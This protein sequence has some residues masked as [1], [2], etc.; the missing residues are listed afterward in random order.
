MTKVKFC[1]LR[2]PEDAA[3]ALLL[4]AAYGGV[5]FAKSKRQVTPRQ[6]QE[7]FD[8]AQSLTRVGVF[9]RETIPAILKIAV[10]ARLD[11][12]QLHAQF[13]PDEHAQL[14]QEFDGEIWSVI[15]I[16][17]ETGSCSA[18]WKDVADFADALLLDTSRG[19]RSGGTGEMFDWKKAAPLIHA[20]STEIPVVLAG[21]LKPDNVAAAI[22][23]LQTAVVDVSSGVEVS[24]GVKSPE[25]MTA[26]ARS[27]A[28]ASIV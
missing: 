28:S 2:R 17:P 8:A 27:V 13:T 20:I 22:E 25:L 14:R 23:I 12:L 3:H 19:G 24:P 26:F 10:E 18:S 5:I 7:V 4:G 11:V 16:D 9:T 21:G 15:G 6:A 1:G